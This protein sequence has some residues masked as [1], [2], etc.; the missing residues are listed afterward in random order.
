MDL[1]TYPQLCNPQNLVHPSGTSSA[2]QP[3]VIRLCYTPMCFG[4][5]SRVASVQQ[6][7]SALYLVPHSAFFRCSRDSA[8]LSGFRAGV[9]LLL[10]LRF[11]QGAALTNQ[12][13]DTDQVREDGQNVKDKEGIVSDGE[14]IHSPHHLRHRQNDLQKNVVL[15]VQ[16]YREQ[17][18]SSQRQQADQRKPVDPDSQTDLQ[19]NEY[20][21]PQPGKGHEH[22]K[23]IAHD[24]DQI[25]G[26]T[27]IAAQH[28]VA[29]RLNGKLNI[30][31]NEDGAL[32]FQQAADDHDHGTHKGNDIGDQNNVHS[33]LR[34]DVLSIIVPL[35]L[36]VN[37]SET[38]KK[39][40]LQALYS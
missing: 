17:A 12:Q 33:H 11:P 5:I 31:C 20:D 4:E 29:H 37:R 7:H 24:A 22:A 32:G 14:V 39:L 10:R 18:G 21:L 8:C 19:D 38:V 25:D 13:E 26:S 6:R 34:I 1:L 36:K 2:E 15:G 23:N 35:A 40:P 28:D 27:G 16:K 3:W 9:R 30:L